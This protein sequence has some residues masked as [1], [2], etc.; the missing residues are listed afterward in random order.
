MG[1]MPF[2]QDKEAMLFPANHTSIYLTRCANKIGTMLKM[3]LPCCIICFTSF[4]VLSLANES[5]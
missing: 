1:D 5:I 3:A 4:A 2:L